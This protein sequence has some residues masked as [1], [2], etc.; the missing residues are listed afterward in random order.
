MCNSSIFSLFSAPGFKYPGPKELSRT[1]A[2]FLDSH[3]PLLHNSAFPGSYR[4]QTYGLSSSFHIVFARYPPSNGKLR[5]F[6][7][8]LEALRGASDPEGRGLEWYGVRDSGGA[9]C[10]WHVVCKGSLPLLLSLKGV[11]PLEGMR[12]A[13]RR[14]V[15]L[16]PSKG[17]GGGVVRYTNPLKGRGD[18][19]AWAEH[20]EQFW[21]GKKMA[22]DPRGE[23]NERAYREVAREIE[24]I[25]EEDPTK[26]NKT[27]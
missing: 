18:C 23:G 22:G 15:E 7:R 26:Q 20:Y 5:A 8:H 11:I 21:A 25:L 9:S 16:S 27:I 10:L 13:L 17:V 12:S 4:S 6:M 14:E 2:T 19:K 24:R 3:H 1:V